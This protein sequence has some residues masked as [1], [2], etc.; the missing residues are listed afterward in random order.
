[1]Y[2]RQVTASR[3]VPSEVGMAPA[4]ASGQEVLASGR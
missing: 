4:A 3:A 1:L 2:W